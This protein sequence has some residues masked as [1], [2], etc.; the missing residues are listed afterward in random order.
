MRYKPAL[1]PPRAYMQYK[2]ANT[3]HYRV[4]VRGT[5]EVDVCVAAARR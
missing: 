1:L 4:L 5:A 3:P 2:D